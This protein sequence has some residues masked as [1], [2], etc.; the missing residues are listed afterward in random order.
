MT[1]II[2]TNLTKTFGGLTAVDHLSFTVQPGEVV[3][4]WGANGAGKTTALRCL[5][6]LLPFAGDI[7]IN[8]LDVRHKGK[9]IRQQVGFVPQTLNFHD[10]LTTA[11]TL[12]FYARL[13]KRPSGYDFS[14]LLNQL[15]LMSHLQKR[16]E[17]LSGGL[18]QRLALALALLSDPP[19]LLLDEPTANLDIRAR[20]DFLLLLHHLK[21]QGKTMVFSSHRLE[22]VTALADRVLLLEAGRLVIDAPPR[23][24]ERQLGWESTLHIYLPPQTIDPALATL[25]AYGLPV[26]RNGRGVR[27]QVQPGQKGEALRVLHE[28]G[29]TIEDF[30]VE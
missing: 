8:G 21:Q 15:A 2:V 1:M 25:T 28:A 19:I 9:E 4:L 16:V 23:E 26:S 30:T 22:E 13:K 6:H 5:L 7:H 29:I 18:K 24:L 3:A 27:V 20:E 17:T 14:P 11:E 12:T 10:D